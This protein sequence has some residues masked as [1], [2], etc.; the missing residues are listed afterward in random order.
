MNK[1]KDINEKHILFTEE[2]N[3]IDFL[4]KAFFYIKSIKV[5]LTDWKWVVLSLHGALYGFMI[6]ALFGGHYDSVTRL[7]KKHKK[8]MLDKHDKKKRQLIGF[9]EALKL[10]QENTYPMNRYTISK[11]LVL[12][13]SQKKSIEALHNTLRN[14]FNHYKPAHWLIEKN[15]LPRITLDTLEAIEFL[16]FKSSNIIQIDYDVKE[17]LKRKINRAKNICLKLSESYSK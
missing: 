7:V 13:T 16:I 11:P 6:C 10:C 15:M 8:E 1:S 4:E 12:T 9:M 5:K 2:S 14:T 3:A 17:G